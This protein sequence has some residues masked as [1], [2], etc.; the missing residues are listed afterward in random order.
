MSEACRAEDSRATVAEDG[1]ASRFGGD[2]AYLGEGYAVEFL[3]KTRGAARRDGEEQLEVFAAVE[4]E[5]ER[6]GVSESG[7]LNRGVGGDK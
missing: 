3:G 1:D 6:V 7:W 2:F 4:G 5:G